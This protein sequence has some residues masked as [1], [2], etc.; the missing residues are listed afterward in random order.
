MIE[1][2]SFGATIGCNCQSVLLEDSLTKRRLRV[3]LMALCCCCW[4][5]LQL[6]VERPWR[7]FGEVSFVVDIDLLLLRREALVQRP[8]D[9]MMLL[10]AACLNDA[11][12]RRRSTLLLACNNVA[13]TAATAEKT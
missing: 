5:I 4:K 8:V 10:L 12:Q 6:L 3:L 1:S 9:L 13:T 2:E 7:V 11:S